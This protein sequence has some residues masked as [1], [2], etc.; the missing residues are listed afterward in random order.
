MS[1]TLWPG[2]AS[3]TGYD[4]SG[5]TPRAQTLHC[6]GDWP[7]LCGSGGRFFHTW[8][9]RSHRIAL[10]RRVIGLDINL[11]RLE[12]LRRGIDSTNETSFDELR[13]AQYLEFTSDTEQLANADVSVTVPTPIDSAKRPT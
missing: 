3:F 7:G 10:K 8:R 4:Q 11:Q 13:S 2:T 9:L 12:E 1:P 6:R 5:F